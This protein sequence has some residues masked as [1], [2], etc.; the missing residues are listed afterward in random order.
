MSFRFGTR[1]LDESLP[2]TGTESI[3]NLRET[4]KGH[5]PQFDAYNRLKN[6]QMLWN[7]NAQRE[8]GSKA[9][10]ASFNERRRWLGRMR[11]SLRNA[12]RVETVDALEEFFA[13]LRSRSRHSESGVYEDA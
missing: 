5:N 4:I 7:E 10:A 12:I 1:L 8:A 13:D 6:L 3:Y 9:S 2:I 11:I